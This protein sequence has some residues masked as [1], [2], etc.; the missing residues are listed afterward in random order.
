MEIELLTTE[1]KVKLSITAKVSSLTPSPAMARK[2]IG[3]LNGSTTRPWSH[4]LGIGHPTK[5]LYFIMKFH[6]VINARRILEMGLQGI[7]TRK[8]KPV[9]FPIAGN[10]MLLKENAESK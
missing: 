9:T 8:T 5:Y 6:L 1:N 4:T 2:M 7:C 3:L 10:E